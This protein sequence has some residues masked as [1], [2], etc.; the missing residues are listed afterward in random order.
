M[1]VIFRQS[2][3]SEKSEKLPP[4]L[5]QLVARLSNSKEMMAK[6]KPRGA[7]SE[8]PSDV[9]QSMQYGKYRRGN[10]ILISC[11]KI[12]KRECMLISDMIS[13]IVLSLFV[14]LDS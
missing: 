14:Y 1:I 8:L 3:S 11:D 7:P 5:F 6:I 4:K 12:N 10:Y 13:L 2:V 9:K